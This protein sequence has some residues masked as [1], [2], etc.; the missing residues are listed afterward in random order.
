VLAYPFICI[1]KE[2]FY[3]VRP[4]GRPRYKWENNIK[5]DFREIGWGDMGWIRLAQN[6]R[7]LVD[8]AM[9][10]RVPGNIGKFLS[11]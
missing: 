5:V 8:T 7:A 9:S 6:G 3:S 10:L 11:S 2:L 4:L 1:Y